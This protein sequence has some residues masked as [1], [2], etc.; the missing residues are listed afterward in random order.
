MDLIGE[1]GRG[2]EG[3]RERGR[4]GEGER[5]RGRE[6]DRE[7]YS[8]SL[9]AGF[10]FGECQDGTQVDSVVL[11]DWAKGDPRLFVLKHRQVR[12]HCTMVV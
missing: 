5:K 8:Y 2:R 7:R 6:I 12:L 3:E 1:T 11:P 4:E 9:F 10:N